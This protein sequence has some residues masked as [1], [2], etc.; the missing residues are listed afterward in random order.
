MAL[1]QLQCCKMEDNQIVATS[2][3]LQRACNQIVHDL[4]RNKGRFQALFA[5]HILHDKLHLAVTA[6][7]TPS[8]LSAQRKLRYNGNTFACMANASTDEI[9]SINGRW[10]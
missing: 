10:N 4:T 2:E 7:T 8:I 3:I 5:P 1:L 9:P 6:V